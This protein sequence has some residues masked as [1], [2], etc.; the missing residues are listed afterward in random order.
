MTAR[1]S[2]QSFGRTFWGS[3]LSLLR[4]PQ[5]NP[6]ETG[7]LD[8]GG[9]SGDVPLGLC[10]P[11]QA[12][13]SFDASSLTVSLCFLTV[14]ICQA[15]IGHRARERFN[16]HLKIDADSFNKPICRGRFG[17]LDGMVDGY[18]LGARL[19]THREM[20][21]PFPGAVVR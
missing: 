18:I 3:R 10:G 20:R 19:L 12:V 13:P 9:V 7:R 21:E 1:E 2:R 5:R 6:E 16:L 14:C 11:F 4:M 15:H 8:Q 17:Y